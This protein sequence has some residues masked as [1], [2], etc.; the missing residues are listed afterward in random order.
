MP[1][2]Q[3]RSQ[4][5]R[6]HTG[7]AGLVVSHTHFTYQFLFTVLHLPRRHRGTGWTRVRK[8]PRE[9]RGDQPSRGPSPADVVQ[10]AESER[11]YSRTALVEVTRHDYSPRKWRRIISQRA[12]CS[13]SESLS[14]YILKSLSA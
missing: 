7:S 6:L 5:S 10:P 1:G 13:A 4:W 14:L 9:R 11:A 8:C 2:G 12:A 3:C